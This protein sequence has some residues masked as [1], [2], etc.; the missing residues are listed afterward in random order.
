MRWMWIDRIVE[1]V[2][3]ERLVAIKNISMAEE[4]LHD[5]FAATPQ[6]PAMP[7]M[8]ASL[9]VEGMAQTAGMLV[10]H[11]SDF[12]EQVILAKVLQAELVCGLLGHHQAMAM[13]HGPVHQIEVEVGQA[14][15]GEAD[16]EAPDRKGEHDAGKQQ[17]R[18]QAQP[19]DKTDSACSCRR[20]SGC[21]AHPRPS[22][23]KAI[24]ASVGVR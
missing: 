13:G 23:T 10:G 14:K 7:V 24:C 15:I 17:Q 5:H 4:H 8:P 21:F 19:G 12:K 11:A 20:G 16:R 18:G 1:L 9:I 6:R 22:R 3:R 2:P